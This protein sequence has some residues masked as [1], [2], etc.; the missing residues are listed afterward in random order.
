V[1]SSI[2]ARI[3]ALFRAKRDEPRDTDQQCLDP[4]AHEYW[5]EHGLP[6]LVCRRRQRY[7]LP[8]DP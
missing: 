4:E 1:A 8:E 3:L 7:L 5:T 2:L 6:C